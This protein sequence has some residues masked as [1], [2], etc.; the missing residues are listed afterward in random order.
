M[1]V[2]VFSNDAVSPLNGAID[3]NDLTLIV[4]S[5]SDFPATG[6]FRIKIDDEIMLVTGVSSNTFT[7]TR[8]QEGTAA[9][10][11][12]DNATVAHVLTAGALD[13]RL[14]DEVYT[15]TYANRLAV[16]KSGR[17]FLPNNGFQ[18]ERDTGAAW[19]PWGPLFPL[20]APVSNDFAWINQGSASITTTNGGIYLLAPAHTGI[21]YKV[22]KKAAPATPYTITAAFLPQVRSLDNHSCGLLFRQS[23]DGKLAALAYVHATSA[24]NFQSLKLTSPTAFSAQYT[25]ETVRQGFG[26]LMFMRIADN[27]T[28]RI[29]SYS[30][31]GVNFMALHTVGRTDFLTADEVGFFSNSDTTGGDAAMTLLSWKQA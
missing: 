13:T 26:P 20:T 6:N 5:A 22:R 4:D 18:I 30:V 2:E 12:L 11:H 1:A 8:A 14:I 19:A 9:A 7:V 21:D 31:D 23:S 24:M 29:V 3:D 28:S 16:A 10:S 15:D 25:I 17:L 27:G